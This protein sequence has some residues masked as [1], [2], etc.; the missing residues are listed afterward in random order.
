MA[1]AVTWASEPSD[2]I[3]TTMA[4]NYQSSLLAGRFSGLGSALLDRFKTTGSDF[5][6]S[7]QVTMPGS[8]GSSV[9]A[10]V[11]LT[12]RTKSGAKV[13]LV[14]H[15]QEDGLSVSVKSSAA[16]SDAE[17]REL[18][19]LSGAFQDALDG[20]SALPPTLALSGLMQFD[21][22][23]LSSIDLTSDVTNEGQATQSIEFHADSSARSVKV[24]GPA[25]AMNVDVDLRNSAIWGDAAQRADAISDYLQQFDKAASRGRGDASLTAM[26]KQAFTQMNGDYGAASQ[27]LPGTSRAPAL[28]KANHAM[29]TG[30]ADFNVSITGKTLSS[31]PRHLIERDAFSY[32]ASQSTDMYGN[33]TSGTISQKQQSR[34]SASYHAPLPGHGPLMLTADKNS[35]SYYYMQIDDMSESTTAI[36]N[37]NGQP[38]H[39]SLSQSASQTTHQSKYDMDKLVSDITTPAKE[40]QSRDLLAL[41]KPFF[42]EGQARQDSNAWHGALSDLHD[43]ILLQPDPSRLKTN[44]GTSIVNSTATANTRT[45]TTAFIQ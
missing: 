18:A 24:R 20:L 34:L 16:L 44:A 8:T 10:D 5:T 13:D 28:A 26:F 41:L 2:P 42:E 7:V 25:G 32:Q 11:T 15:S 6:Q 27:A 37:K 33:L 23:V 17:R 1:P 21:K 9:Q 4:G 14:L 30:L 35:Q 36:E 31:N 19:K 12:I 3:S 45:E 39:A 22:S 29:L 43:M 40:S 38:V